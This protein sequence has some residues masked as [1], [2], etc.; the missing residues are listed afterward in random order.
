M[1]GTSSRTKSKIATIDA[2]AE[3]WEPAAALVQ[4][5]VQSNL[6]VIE[7]DKYATNPLFR[8][9]DGRGAAI[10]FISAGID[11]THPAFLRADGS[12]RVVYQYDFVNGD[13]IADDKADVGTHV[14][15]LARAAER[16]FFL[17][18]GVDL[19][20]HARCQPPIP[21]VRARCG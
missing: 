10:V 16:F 21:R 7:W 17:D 19:R 3:Q 6:D 2:T 20:D 12:S 1:V 9:V 8:D 14:A 4:T 11:A 15:S 5:P 18:L 13:I